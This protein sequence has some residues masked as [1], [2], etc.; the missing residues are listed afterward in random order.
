MHRVSFFTRMIL[1][2]VLGIFVALTGLRQPVDVQHLDPAVATF[3]EAGGTLADI[4][5]GPGEPHR[6]NMSHC[7]LCLPCPALQAASFDPASVAVPLEP[8]PMAMP[9]SAAVRTSR[10]RARANCVR[11][12]PERA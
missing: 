4:C 9:Q 6:K 7:A 5:D 8:R 3:L 10:V 12:P 2:L 1:A 11:A